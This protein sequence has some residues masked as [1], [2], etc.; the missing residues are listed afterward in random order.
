MTIDLSQ[1]F[2]S[3]EVKFVFM[4]HTNDYPLCGGPLPQ[5]SC[6]SKSKSQEFCN[7]E[8]LLVGAIYL[9]AI[10]CVVSTQETGWPLPMGLPITT[11]SG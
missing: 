4:V 2:V 8:G 11:M 9:S 7:V 10:G 5:V 1:E 6:K 3:A